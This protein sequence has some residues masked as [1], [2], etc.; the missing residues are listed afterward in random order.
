MIISDSHQFVF[1]KGRKV[2][3]TSIEVG[4]SHICGPDDVLTPITPADEKVRY[5]TT[6]RLAQNFGAKSSQL[7][8]F[9]EA[10][11]TT[12][13]DVIGEK[14]IRIPRG[15]YRGHMPLKQIEDVH[16]PFPST[17]QIIGISRSP[18]EQVLSRI[19]H[20]LSIEA[21]RQGVVS[22]VDP[23]HPSFTKA[24]AD[25]MQKI[26]NQSLNLNVNMYKNSAGF[27]A[28]TRILRYENLSNDFK[29]LMHDMGSKDCQKLPHLKKTTTRRDINLKQIFTNAEIES[30]N[31]YFSEEFTRF[32]Y[33]VLDC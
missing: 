24:K 28:I 3:G 4:L 17:Y 12:P 32:N 5:R 30:I 29:K 11:K 13:S 7:E 6:G 15:S 19:K 23:D 26:Q 18:Y 10:I 1:I 2:A 31:N 27:F 8:S 33:P 20:R 16:G 9:H 21:I 25:V 14:K 22:Q